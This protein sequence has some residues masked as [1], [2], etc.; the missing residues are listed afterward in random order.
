MRPDGPIKGADMRPKA[1]QLWGFGTEEGEEGGQTCAVTFFL[2]FLPFCPG[3]P[4]RAVGVGWSGKLLSFFSTA[5]DV[6]SSEK[7]EALLSERS[8]GGKRWATELS[9]LDHDWSTTGEVVR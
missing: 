9:T 4:A 1:F 3:I 2:L 5:R 8:R 6:G 7:C